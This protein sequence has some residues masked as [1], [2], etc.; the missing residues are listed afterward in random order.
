MMILSVVEVVAEREDIGVAEATEKAEDAQKRSFQMRYS[1][2]S[3]RRQRSSQ[4]GGD[5]GPPNREETKAEAQKSIATAEKQSAV[6]Y[7]E[8]GCCWSCQVRYRSETV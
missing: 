8:V 6:M 4:S 3:G 7:L 5:K 2:A 1:W